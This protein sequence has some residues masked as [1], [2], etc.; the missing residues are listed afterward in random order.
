MNIK[1]IF[2]SMNP[3]S[4]K[5]SYTAPFKTMSF[6]SLFVKSL[7]LNYKADIIPSTF[8]VPVPGSR[9]SIISSKKF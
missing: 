2:T 7:E 1:Y 9:N 8:L 3:Q 5:K 6:I 4:I